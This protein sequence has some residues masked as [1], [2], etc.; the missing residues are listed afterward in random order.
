MIKKVLK[1]LILTG[2]VILVFGFMIS[3][4]IEKSSRNFV[5]SEAED[6]PETQVALV[7]GARVWKDDVLSHTLQDRVDTAVELYKQKKV[8]K[9]LLSGD[10]GREEYDEVNAMKNYLL[11]R[12]IPA[13]DIFLDHAGFDTYDSVYR[14][15]E[16]FQVD[17]MT[18]VTQEFHLP[19][20]IYIAKCLDIKAYGLVSDKRVYLLAKRNVV[21]EKIAQQKAFLDCFFNSEPKFLGEEIPITGDSKKSWDEL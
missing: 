18:I 20:S 5:F 7:L 19:R 4:R 8:K 12:G 2:V 17:S 15:K 3:F 21:R 16:I 11:D 13:R 6:V 14:A 10:H 1:I 9:F